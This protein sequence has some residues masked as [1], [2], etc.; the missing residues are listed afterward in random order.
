[1]AARLS[2][3]PARELA[4]FTTSVF[5]PLGYRLVNVAASNEVKMAI[6]RDRF[7]NSRSVHHHYCSFM[8]PD[9]VWSLQR[10]PNPACLIC[11]TLSGV[12]F[13]NTVSSSNAE[14]DERHIQKTK[15]GR[16]GNYGGRLKTPPR[17]CQLGDRIGG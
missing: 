9:Y 12:R 16:N 13:L 10:V 6:V 7:D 2:V 5:Y 8:K 17:H 4:R 1:M 3:R 15:I 11:S 14:V